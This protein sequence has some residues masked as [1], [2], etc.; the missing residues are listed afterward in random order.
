MNKHI[1][2]ERWSCIELSYEGKSFEN[3]FTQAQ[4]HGVFVNR[5]ETIE[6]E[7]FYDGNNIFKIR[8]MPSFIGQYSYTISGNFTDTH[9]VGIIE[10]TEATGN[11]RGP[12]KVTDKY[13][14]TYENGTPYYSIGT[15][16]YAWTHQPEKMRA[17]TIET[18]AGSPFN[19][20]R[21]CV[22]P[23]HY[24]YNLYEPDSYPYEGT[25]CDIS[26]INKENFKEY[27]PSNPQ[28]KWDYTRF[29]PE[30][31]HIIDNAI[32]SLL[33]LGIEAD[34]IL[35]HPYDRWGFSEMG[36][37][38]DLQYLRYAIARFAAYRN[39]WWSLANEYD[40]CPGKS[41][42]DWE[43]IADTI[44]KFDPYTRL[45]SI[46][47]CKKI[48]DYTRPW[49][50]HCSIQRTEIVVS[51]ANAHVWREQYGKP[52]VL[53]EVGYEGN[54]DHNWGN[55]SAQ[56][57]VRL[58]WVAT[59][60]GGYC[61]H[62]E[63]YVHPQDKLWWSHGSKLYG[64]SMPRL[65]FLKQILDEVPGL[66]LQPA[67]LPKTDNNVATAAHPRYT[68]KF[69]LFYTDRNQPSFKRFYFDDTNKYRVEVIDTWDMTIEQKGEF[70]GLFRVDLPAKQYMAIRI[71]QVNE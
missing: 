61:G 15:T 54:I 66:G 33:E 34:I 45:R 53:D 10:V 8:F 21:F 69:Y 41:A 1:S 38:N 17:Q 9:D 55:L 42:E 43:A 12:V 25:P 48:Y 16:C 62:G 35:F 63:T 58:F 36:R 44:V 39:V 14:F 60:R 26:G 30:H 49:V 18:L 32:Q 2:A 7:G 57:M 46:H 27:L 3:P 47:N 13:H 23:K 52:I 4:I 67:N 40:L 51:A 64:N 68:E 6:T 28:N 19:K 11:N 20:L 50:T 31:F 70:S 65:S 29:N 37:E 71:L 56:E 59:V 24:D 22:F 5:N